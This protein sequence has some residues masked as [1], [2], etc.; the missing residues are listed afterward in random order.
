M[1]YIHTLEYYSALKREEILTHATHGWNY[2]KW[3]KPL[4]C[5]YCIIPLTWIVSSSQIKKDRE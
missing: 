1:W 2:T 4:K 5:K 3:H